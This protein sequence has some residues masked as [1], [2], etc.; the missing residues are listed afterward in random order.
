M[1]YYKRPSP[2]PSTTD[3]KKRTCLCGC[4]KR[5][6]GEAVY[7]SAACRKRRQ[8]ALDAADPKAVTRRKRASRPAAKTLAATKSVVRK[9]RAKKM[10]SG[11]KSNT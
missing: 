1:G 8:R 4:G 3:G 2:V 11:K 6:T 10:P 7:F 5:V 9:S